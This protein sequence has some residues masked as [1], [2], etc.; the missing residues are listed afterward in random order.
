MWGKALLLV[1]EDF[2]ELLGNPWLV[3][4]EDCHILEGIMLSPQTEMYEEIL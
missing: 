4:W 2:L 3:V 1:V